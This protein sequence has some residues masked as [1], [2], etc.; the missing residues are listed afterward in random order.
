MGR[1]E[2]DFC[3]FLFPSTTVYAYPSSSPS[4]TSPSSTPPPTYSSSTHSSSHH[5]YSSLSITSPFKLYPS[6]TQFSST[7]DG[8]NL[9]RQCT[10]E[11]M[12]DGASNT[13]NFLQTRDIHGK[14]QNGSTRS[15]TKV[16]K[17][18]FPVG[19]SVDLTKFNN[20]TELTAELDWLFEFDGALVDPN[21]MKNW[22]IVYT[23]I[24][25]DLIL[26]GNDP[27]Q[28]FVSM[29]RKIYIYKREMT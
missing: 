29:V 25:D 23:D 19:R 22:V 6:T 3:P 8:A 17:Q 15:C 27:W 14:A 28:E 5:S 16:H 24:E 18:G 1:N 21:P 26:F 20:Y 13:V 9:N 12:V 4:S 10:K 7:A 2:Q 11:I